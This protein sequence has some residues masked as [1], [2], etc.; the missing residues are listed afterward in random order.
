[1]G[2]VELWLEHLG[3]DHRRGAQQRVVFGL[4]I[5]GRDALLAAFL[6]Q[7][8]PLTAGRPGRQSDPLV[9]VR[10]RNNSGG[11]VSA[12]AAAAYRGHAEVVRLLV[13][14]AGHASTRDRALTLA[15]LGQHPEVVADLM[16]GGADPGGYDVGGYNAS[17]LALAML[18]EASLAVFLEHDSKG[19][20]D[21]LSQRRYVGRLVAEGL[22][23][24]LRLLGRLGGGL[25]SCSEVVVKSSNRRLSLRIEKPNLPVSS[26]LVSQAD[27]WQMMI[28]A[29]LDLDQPVG[30][31]RLGDLLLIAASMGSPSLV[32]TLLDAGY[33]PDVPDTFG[34]TALMVASLKKQSAVIA[35][36]QERGADPNRVNQDGQSA[37]SLLPDDATAA[38]R[39]AL[40]TPGGVGGRAAPTMADGAAG[41]SP[42]QA[43]RRLRQYIRDGEVAAARELLDFALVDFEDGAGAG[44]SVL[45]FALD[46]G[47]PEIAAL[48]AAK[49][50]SL[51]SRRAGNYWLGEHRFIQA[52]ALDYTEVAQV[53]MTRSSWA[54]DRRAKIYAKA[55]KQTEEEGRA[56][57]AAWL[58]GL[59]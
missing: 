15:V 42:M 46:Q 30:E 44:R 31:A 48:I 13:P 29:G 32:L 22:Y 26:R 16:A 25:A 27:H 11:Q 38:L 28:D 20:S 33:G 21:S 39:T 37:L 2:V 50:W 8:L 57:T 35:L 49:D 41:P 3:A 19:V 18:D 34:T 7:A 4:A 47:Q 40:S 43:A 24:S 36:L 51:P 14:H 52:V 9:G 53:I 12:L 23:G 10:F 58:K 17:Q 56:T 5:A 6:P 1:M 54:P 59:R 55:L 45:K